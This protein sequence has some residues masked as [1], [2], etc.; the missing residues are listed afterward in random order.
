MN[1]TASSSESSDYEGFRNPSSRSSTGPVVIDLGNSASHA[2]EIDSLCP[3]SA[4]CHRSATK[5]HPSRSYMNAS[6]FSTTASPNTN[7]SS[8]EMLDYINAPT[9]LGQ[10][11]RNMFFE[12]EAMDSFYRTPNVADFNQALPVWPPLNDSLHATSSVDDNYSTDFATW[13]TSAAPWPGTSAECSAK[14]V[15]AES[16]PQCYVTDNHSGF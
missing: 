2:T 14:E 7:A 6:G 10:P 1:H 8:I 9:F 12:P 16:I 15:C 5:Y 4:I 3:T 11:G 13:P